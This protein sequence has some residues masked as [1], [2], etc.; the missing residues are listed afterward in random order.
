MGRE[1]EEKLALPSTGLSDNSG[2]QNVA[3]TVHPACMFLQDHAVG[4]RRAEGQE[5]RLQ[6]P[7][8]TNGLSLKRSDA[9]ARPPS[10]HWGLA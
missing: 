3:V 5:L 10:G 7:R 4:P 2:P 6:G 1:D 8:H 9:E